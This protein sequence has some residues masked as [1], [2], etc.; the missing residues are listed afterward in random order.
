MCPLAGLSGCQHYNYRN[1][2]R[3]LE[4]VSPKGRGRKAEWLMEDL[5]P[6]VREGKPREA[7]LTIVL[8]KLSQ[9]PTEEWLEMASR[10]VD[11]AKIGWGLPLLVDLRDLTDRVRTYQEWDISV[12][13]GGTLL[14]LAEVKGVSSHLLDRLWELGFDAVEVSSGSVDIPL[15]RRL[16][17]IEEASDR[18]FRV[19][20]EVGKKDPER[21]MPLS[22]VIGE[23]SGILKH[24]VAWKVIIEGRESG[25]SACLFDSHGNIRWS[26]LTSL[27]STFGPD[28]LV[29]EAP[30]T[31]QQAALIKYLGPNVNLA[32]ISPSEV[33]SLESLRLGLRGDT[34]MMPSSLDVPGGPSS[35]FVYYLL[36][37][38]GPL[39]TREI[40]RMTGLPRRTVNNAL[41]IL[42][43]AGFVTAVGEGRTAVWVAL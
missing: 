2:E 18:G 37:H 6:E 27:A 29:F 4:M 14:E 16:R 7:G 42:R 17:L 23:I 20:A 22:A 36:K 34:F 38:E 13:V 31:H 8:D 35:K 10:Y 33:L 11:Y 32:N 15:E 28:S 3:G 39:P 40:V 24:G 30:F 9:R 21:Q 12:G 1:A 26:W 43:E 5:V 19:F 41:R 25:K